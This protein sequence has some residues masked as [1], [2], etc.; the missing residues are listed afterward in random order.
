MSSTFVVA[1][2]ITLNLPQSS[3]TENIQTDAITIFIFEDGRLFLGDE[4]FTFT[5][6]SEFFS[7]GEISENAQVTIEG[8]MGTDYQYVV[9]ILDILRKNGIRGAALRA[10]TVN[11]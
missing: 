5:E 10:E 6:L 4:E 2:G 7:S 8:E 3:T 9:T 1:P 11:E